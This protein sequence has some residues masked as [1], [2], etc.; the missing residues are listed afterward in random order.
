MLFQPSRKTGFRIATS[1]LKIFGSFASEE[2]KDRDAI[3][4]QGKSSPTF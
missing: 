1:L 3:T 2:I 4:Y